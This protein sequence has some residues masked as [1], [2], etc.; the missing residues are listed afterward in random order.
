MITIHI[1][2]LFY[3]TGPLKGIIAGY[4]VRALPCDVIYMPFYKTRTGFDGCF[5][6]G[7][8]SNFVTFSSSNI[9]INAPIGVPG[10]VVH[11][12]KNWF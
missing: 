4:T 10:V 5:S 8:L 12:Y 3:V 11:K 1:D 6:H 9:I 7:L 2:A